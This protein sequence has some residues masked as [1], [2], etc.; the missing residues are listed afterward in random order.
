MKKLMTL[1][2][3]VVA[4]ASCSKE[5]EG[6]DQNG[7]AQIRFNS[8]IEATSRAAISTGTAFNAHVIRHDLAEAGTPDFKNL[9]PISAN[10][11]G[12]GKVTITPQYYDVEGAT[13]YFLGFTSEKA[14][15]AST[16]EASTV[17]YTELDGQT[18]I[19]ATSAT[20]AGTKSVPVTVALAYE[21]KLSQLQFKFVAGDGFPTTGKTVTGIS[22]KN[23]KTAA[24][25]TLSGE[26]A[27]S[28]AFT[29]EATEA[30]TI[31]SSCEIIPAGRIDVSTVLV[32]AGLTQIVMDITVGSVTYEN[33]T[34]SLTT[35]ASKAHVITLTFNAKGM[36]EP[37]ATIGAWENGSGGTGN[38]E[39]K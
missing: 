4:L 38:I 30:Y 33:V 22:I 21:H 14:T 20:S 39:D 5:N 26:N 29:G 25:L 35:E 7:Q 19:M 9:A 6:I 11:A 32:E 23:V 15:I 24:T 2:L 1:A 13:S 3:A 36:D 27:P 37:T 18:D 17:A 34:V 8:T 28:L 31:S 10:V 16:G 12:D